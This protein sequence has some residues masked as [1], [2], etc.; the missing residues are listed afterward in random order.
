MEILAHRGY[1]QNPEEKNTLAAF[2]KAFDLGFGIE[3]DI[4]DYKGKIVVEH[5]IPHNNNHELF[6]EHVLEKLQKRDLP[7]AINIKSDGLLNLLSTLLKK[8]D[9][10]N[11]FTFDMSLPEMNRYVNS[12]LAVFS[13][14]SELQIIPP[15]FEKASGIWLD[16]FTGD[17]YGPQL[18]ANLIEKR[19][20]VCVVSDELHNRPPDWQWKMLKEHNLHQCNEVSLCTDWPEKARN[21]FGE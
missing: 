21:Y 12:E 5:D 8:H 20:K 7:L 1:W 10:K 9:I 17:W 14:K 2:C 18:I 13:G 6:F 16:S 11:Y 19:K 3:L 15:F 4:R